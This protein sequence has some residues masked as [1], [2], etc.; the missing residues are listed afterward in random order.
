MGALQ[1]PD[2][3]IIIIII[4]MHG[5]VSQWMLAEREFETAMNHGLRNRGLLWTCGRKMGRM[6]VHEIGRMKTTN[7]RE[8][9]NIKKVLF[10]LKTVI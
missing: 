6:P 4:I 7:C 9:F 1:I 8:N 5:V 10:A 2:M 3:I